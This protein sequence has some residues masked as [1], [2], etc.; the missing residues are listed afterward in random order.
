MMNIIAIIGIYVFVI[1]TASILYTVIQDE[2]WKHMILSFIVGAIIGTL[3]SLFGPPTRG[4][5]EDKDRFEDVE[6]SYYRALVFGPPLSGVFGLLIYLSISFIVDLVVL[7]YNVAHSNIKIILPAV[8]TIT[9]GFLLFQF[10]QRQRVLYGISEVFVG[11]IAGILHSGNINQIDDPKYLLAL[12][13][14]SIYLVVR[15][16]D[17]INVGLKDKNNNKLLKMILGGK[18]F[19]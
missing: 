7:S 5:D 10:R 15:G 14:A 16:L 11:T 12:L 6:H 13:S 18:I 3:P 8:L 17:N 4:P 19:K 9:I 1:I 2:L